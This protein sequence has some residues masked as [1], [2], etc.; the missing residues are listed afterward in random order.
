MATAAAGSSE[1]IN[2][3]SKLTA[4][5]V[6]IKCLRGWKTSWQN[7]FKVD[8]EGSESQRVD[9]HTINSLAQHSLVTQFRRDLSPAQSSFMPMT[10]F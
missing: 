5:E 9:D 2:T 7:I 6:L 4:H 3:R 10:A 8:S 1:Y